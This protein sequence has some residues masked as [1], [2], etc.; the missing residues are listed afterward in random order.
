MVQLYD[1]L[2]QTK[3]EIPFGGVHT[4]A[5]LLQCPDGNVLIYNTSNKD[6]I[7]HI[8][9]L[10]GIKYQFLSHR[11]EAG[12]SLKSIK[13]KFNSALCC[14]IKEEPIIAR[15]CPVDVTF[16]EHTS[17]FC[18]IEVIPTPGHTSGSISFLYHSPKGQNYLFTGD[19]LFQS[20]GH[21]GTIVFPGAG[22]SIEALIDSLEIYRELN[23][24][25]VISSA[26]P[27]DISVVEVT[28]D[29]WKVDIDNKIQELK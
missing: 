29:Q 3:L 4:H 25:V 27:G 23:P 24:D 10:G 11:D 6:D 2:W 12:K 9:E 8:A 19:T 20:N 13:E 22:G 26:S 1:D 21:W 18:S 15:T 5:Y 7:H 28:H 14:H 17:H 16:S